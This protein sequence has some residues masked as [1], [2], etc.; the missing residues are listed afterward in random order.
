MFAVIEA[1]KFAKAGRLHDA[2]QCL[3]R[4]LGDE[5]TPDT[6]GLLA[7]LHPQ[8]DP[9]SLDA[10]MPEAIELDRGSLI[11]DEP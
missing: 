2:Q 4:A 9:I 3:V 1:I 8:R 6:V 10:P 11:G 5:L 7:A